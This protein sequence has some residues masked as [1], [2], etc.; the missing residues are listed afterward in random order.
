MSIDYLTRLPIDLFIKEITYLPFGEV[1]SVCKAN[2]I[3]SNYCT[4]SKYNNQ[5]R[6]LI[7]TTFGNI[8]D[9]HNKLKQIR[10]KLKISEGTYNYLVYSHLVKILDP[11]TQLMIYYRQGDM[12]SFGDPQFTKVQ[13][14]F[15]LFLLNNIKETEKYLPDYYYLPFIYMLNGDKIDQNRLNNMLIEIAEAGSVKGVSMMVSKGA[16]VHYQNDYA[17]RQTSQNGHLDIVKYLVEN[18]A[19]VHADD[20]YAL[21]L[22]SQNGH[23]EVVKYLIEHGAD[24]HALRWTPARASE[25]GHLAVVKYLIEQD[26]NV[27]ADND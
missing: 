14:F 25:K 2:K 27:H 22:A 16:N 24:I 6:S 17:L 9:Y 11:I 10:S 4:N 12:K 13:R 8:Y 19:N 20:D 3:L 7:D 15:A 18:G 23:L 5:W 1:I 21:R 26:A